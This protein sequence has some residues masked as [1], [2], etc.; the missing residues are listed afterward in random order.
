MKIDIIT[1]FPEF[2]ESP[3]RNGLLRRAGEIGLIEVVAHNLRDYTE[4][5]HRS[6]DDA[7]YG[8]GAGMILK[9]EPL[10]RALRRIDAADSHVVYLSPSGTPLSQPVANRLSLLPRLILVC[11]R[12]RGIDQRVVD[13]YVTEEISIGD[14]VVSGGEIPA[15]VL[16]DSVVRLIPGAI[17]DA[18]SALED[19]FQSGLLDCPWYTHPAVFEGVAV[20]DVLLSGNHA[21]IKS[22]RSAMSLR[23]TAERRPDLLRDGTQGT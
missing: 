23:R 19:S 8:G 11:G 21:M 16:I 12:Y 13:R 9:P 18:E 1:I 15:L 7:P 10:A 14:Y 2:F 20:P 17:S 5:R 6:V 22:W 3:L 4:D